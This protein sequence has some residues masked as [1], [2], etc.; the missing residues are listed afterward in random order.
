MPTKDSSPQ[1]GWQK[2]TLVTPSGGG[3]GGGD[4]EDAMA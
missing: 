1:S 4:D 2:D 3:D